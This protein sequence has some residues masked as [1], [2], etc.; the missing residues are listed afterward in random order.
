M[1]VGV[2]CDRC[3]RLALRPPAA[4]RRPAARRA[5]AILTRAFINILPRCRLYRSTLGHFDAGLDTSGR[6]P[7]RKPRLYWSH[8]GAGS[9]SLD[10]PA[11]RAA[12]KAGRRRRLAALRL[13][14]PQ[15]RSPPTSPECCGRADTSPRAAGYYLIPATGEPRGLVHAIEPH[16]LAHL[17]GTDREVRR[18]RTARSRT[19]AHCWRHPPGGHGVL[20][21][22]R[23]PLCLA[24]GRRHRGAGAPVRGRGRVVGRPRAAVLGRLARRGRSRPIWRRRARSTASRIAPSGDCLTPGIRRRHDRVR[25]SAVDGRM[26]QGGRPGQRLGA[27]RVRRR[28]RRQPPLPADSRPEPR[29]SRQRAGA[30]GPLGEARSARLGL[31]GHYMGGLHRHAGSRAAGR[32]LRSGGSGPRRRRVPRAEPCTGGP[33]RSRLG[34]GPR[35]VNRPAR[36]PG[37]GAQILHRTGHSLGETVHGTGVNMDDYETHDDRRLLPGTGF[38]IEPGVYFPDFGIRTEINMIVRAG[39]AEV[40]GPLQSAILALV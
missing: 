28:E 27:E 7:A 14:R 18:P 21:R 22:L 12:L 4:R 6:P 3:L 10:L 19:A 11:I 5:A 32:R 30:A 1:K 24:R 17:P 38:T 31:R 26:V 33:G 35:C 2:G 29:H 20:A 39:S 37:Y 9:E 40:S 13:P 15:S 23:H 25:H 8:M 36:T 16:S 34:G